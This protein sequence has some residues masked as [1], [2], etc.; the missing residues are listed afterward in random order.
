M[1]DTEQE[2]FHD[3]VE[4][5]DLPEA[6]QAAGRFN[7]SRGR[8]GQAPPL[9]AGW[10]F[11]RL[12][13]R[14]R[15]WQLAVITG[16]VAL[17]A[18]IVLASSATT[19]NALITGIV[20]RQPTPTPTLFPGTDLFY[21]QGTPFWGHAS[22]DGRELTRLPIAGTDQPLRLTR[23]S[24]IVR[25]YADPFQPQTCLITIPALV[26]TDAC[27]SHDVVQLKSDLF[28]SIITFSESLDSLP[29]NQREALTRATQVAVNTLP[30]TEMVQPGEQYIDVRS[31]LG[32]AT[33][34]QPMRATLNF[35]LDVAPTSTASCVS[36]LARSVI[37]SCLDCL[38]FCTASNQAF[39]VSPT[40]QPWS[41]YALVS[42]TWKFTTLDGHV[43]E[44]NQPDSPHEH[45]IELQITWDGENWQVS[46]LVNTLET[47]VVGNPICESAQEEIGMNGYFGATGGN[48][49]EAVNWQQFV[50]KANLAAGCLAVGMPQ[51]STSD[52]P[53]LPIAYLLYRF[54][55]VVAGN[56]AA[57]R[58]WASQ[59]LADAYEQHLVQQLVAQ[60]PSQ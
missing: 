20:G 29:D 30:S 51:Q 24:H 28:A 6:T 52:Q 60:L 3:D 49:E 53:H 36:G 57:Y 23:G 47:P 8:A 48:V 32:V 35:Q 5:T 17:I 33:A 31:N 10:P 2:Q 18:L 58:Y 34:R 40:N 39:P 59:A 13:P 14:Q 50:S 42:A 26:G 41:I 4:I 45:L 37:P 12:S 46:V 7:I 55:V 16:S 38:Q 21:I 11:R 43:V 27:L 44:Q 1:D 19:R 22:L 54:G 9:L 56:D 15:V 25:W